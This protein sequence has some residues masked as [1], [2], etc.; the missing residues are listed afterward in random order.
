MSFLHFVLPLV[1]AGA[2]PSHD[3]A[4]P[5]FQASGQD[6]YYRGK[7]GFATVALARD[8]AYREFQREAHRGRIHPAKGEYFSY[9]Y[10]LDD[11]G[12]GKQLFFHTQWQPA[13]YVGTDHGSMKY[14]AR[15]PFQ[16]AETLRVYS[17]MHSHPRGQSGGAGPSR[18]D[19][20]TASQF[21]NP[22]GS[23]RY[24]YLINNHGRLIQFK[25]RRDIDPGD[26]AALSRLP[27]RPRAGHDWLD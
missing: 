23:Y 22:D 2:T 24:L 12:A 7:T 21:K 6:P 26:T 20:A 19:V 13:V 17:L 8:H 16:D 10:T 5:L 9:L 27:V 4:S 14:I 25:A 3:P 11:P 18:V 1:L 15:R